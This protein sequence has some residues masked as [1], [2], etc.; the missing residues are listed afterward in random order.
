M[1]KRNK[2]EWERM[3]RNKTPA[4]AAAFDF[5][6][7]RCRSIVRFCSFLFDLQF[8]DIKHSDGWTSQSSF[9]YQ[10]T[11]NILKS[12]EKFRNSGVPELSPK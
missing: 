7:D 10:A 5:A 2:K 8:Q 1:M 6:F 9:A 12:S 3:K 4:F 11:I